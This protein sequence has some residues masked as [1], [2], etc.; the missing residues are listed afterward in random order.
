MLNIFMKI[1]KYL[2]LIFLND[3]DILV[4]IIYLKLA[5]KIIP[6]LVSY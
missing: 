5:L 4:F 2:R 6:L 3:S 1:Y